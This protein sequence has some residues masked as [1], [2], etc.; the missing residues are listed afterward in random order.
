MEPITPHRFAPEGRTDERPVCIERVPS[1]EGSVRP[2]GAG[3]L[4]VGT[5][6]GLRCALP[7]ATAVRPFGAGYL[8]ARMFYGFRLPLA[9]ADQ[10]MLEHRVTDFALKVSAKC[11]PHRTHPK[12]DQW[13]TLHR[14]KPSYPSHRV[15]RSCS[16][17]RRSSTFPTMKSM[18]SSTR[19]G[20]R[21]SPGLVGQTIAP[22]SVTDRI[23][24]ISTRLSGVSR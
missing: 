22:A 17:C 14:V 24:S 1:R 10:S 11:A 21:Y 9:G 7:V 23:F 2:S 3:L 4:A 16:T 8:E 13:H 5:F 19:C 6:H 20:W 18:R 15:L 12:T